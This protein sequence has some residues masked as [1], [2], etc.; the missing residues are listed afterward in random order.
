M[1][2]PGANSHSDLDRHSQ[3]TNPL[4]LNLGPL[5]NNSKQTLNAQTI[6]QVSLASSYQ[7]PALDGR[8]LQ[9]VPLKLCL[10][11]R[12]P[13]IAVVYKLESNHR[14]I[15]STKSSKR[16]DKK[17]IHEIFVDHLTRKTDLKKLCEK[18]CETESQYLNPT[19]ISKTQ[20]GLFLYLILNVGA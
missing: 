16:H 14:T 20:V 18:M 10:K 17:Y 2:G 8:L 13:T 6:S 15:G 11:F 12:P 9:A 7:V 5:Q 3:K 4:S 19:V 1:K